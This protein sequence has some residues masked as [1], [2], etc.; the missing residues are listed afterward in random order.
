MKAGVDTSRTYWM[1]R[2]LKGLVE[3]L[4]YDLHEICASNFI[5]ARS[6]GQGGSGYPGYAEKCWPGV[7]M[8][9]TAA[10]SSRFYRLC[11]GFI[12]LPDLDSNQ[13]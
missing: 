5:F 6:P 2:R 12:E 11:R 7:N 3:E 9:E 1:Q 8:I 10:S 4:S 13:D